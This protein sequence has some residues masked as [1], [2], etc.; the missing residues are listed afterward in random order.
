VT[1]HSQGCHYYQNRFWSYFTRG[2]GLCAPLS[3][4]PAPI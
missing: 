4:H 1:L 2:G 3:I